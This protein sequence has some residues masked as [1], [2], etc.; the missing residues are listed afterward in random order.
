MPM[1][2]EAEFVVASRLYS[3]SMKSAKEIRTHSGVAIEHASIQE[4]FR[5][6]RDY[7]EEVSGMKDCHHNAVMHHRIALYGPPCERCRKPLRTPNAKLCGSCMFP[8]QAKEISVR[9]AV[10]LPKERE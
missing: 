1:L 6:V 5:P 8:V 9:S 10:R 2:D 3:E 7:Y 4:R